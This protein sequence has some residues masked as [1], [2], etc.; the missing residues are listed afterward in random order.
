VSIGRFRIH[1]AIGIARVGN[2]DLAPDGMSSDGFFIGPETPGVPANW[3]F[4]TRAF[5]SFKTDGK[6]KRQAA[7]FH[8]WEYEQ[9]NGRM[10]PKRP[11]TRDTSDVDSIRWIVDVANTKASFYTFEQDQG[12]AGRFFASHP[13]RNDDVPPRERAARLEIRPGPREIAGSFAAPVELTNPEPRIPIRTLG[14]LRTD[15]EGRLVFLG[16]SGVAA[17]TGDD[18]MSHPYNNSGWFDDVSDGPV[19]AIVTVRDRDGRPESFQADG[20]WVIVGPPDFA[21]AIESVVTLWDLML[22]LAVRTRK[23][24]PDN[25]LFTA[26]ERGRGLPG[27]A[28]LARAWEASKDSSGRKRP[29]EDYVPSYA[30]QILPILSRATAM[31]GVHDSGYSFHTWMAP[32]A[33]EAFGKLPGRRDVREAIF[34]WLRDPDEGQVRPWLMPRTFA[35][36]YAVM[37]RVGSRYLAL[38]RTQYALL[39]Q[40]SA[41][42]F[43]ADYTGPIQIPPEPDLSPEGLDRAALQGCSGGGFCPGME[44]GW[45]ITKPQVYAEAFRIKSGATV[46]SLSVGP[47][48][49]SQQVALPWHADFWECQK[50]EDTEA[51]GIWQAWWPSNRPDDVRRGGEDAGLE[52]SRGVPTKDDMVEKWSTR[53]FVLPSPDGGFVEHEGPSD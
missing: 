28:G 24:L 5:S 23:I 26:Y 29:L 44:V 40:W 33:L 31:P 53:G 3:D 22:D 51:A 36:N 6:V 4:G 7:R 19:K 20:A 49:F 43:A 2:A 39:R 42:E 8:I 15:A 14:Q 46:D 50:E 21:P 27:V 25:G 10:I 16:G 18:P 34:S 9:R 11:V 12:S 30:E 35:D 38:T 13:R 32:G 45:L 52:W 1:P 47:G 37:P 48:F 17:N 41:G